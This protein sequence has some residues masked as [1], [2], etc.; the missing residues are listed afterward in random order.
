MPWLSVQAFLVWGRAR[1]VAQWV[2]CRFGSFL[3]DVQAYCK[4]SS[5][6]SSVCLGFFLG[7]FAAIATG[8]VTS[9][10]NL[11]FCAVAEACKTQRLREEKAAVGI[12]PRS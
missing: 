4:L 3:I 6:A 7:L 2:V 1:G 9:F 10:A 5:A 11:L 8:L 12:I